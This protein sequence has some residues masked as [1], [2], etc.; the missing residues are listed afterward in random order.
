MTAEIIDKV[1]NTLLMQGSP[2][3]VGLLTGGFIV[4]KYFTP[5]SNNGVSRAECER[6]HKELNASLKT[7]FTSGDKRMEIIEADQKE[8]LGHLIAIKTLLGMKKDKK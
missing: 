2:A 3:V 5:K 6:V 8:A 1:L 7:N 4:K